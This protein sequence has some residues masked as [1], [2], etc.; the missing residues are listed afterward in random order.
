LLLRHSLLLLLLLSGLGLMIE[1]RRVKQPK[2]ACNTSAR[3]RASMVGSATT[4]RAAN[5]NTGWA[6]YCAC[7][8]MDCERKIRSIRI[9]ISASSTEGFGLA[10]RRY[11]SASRMLP[12]ATNWLAYS[13]YFCDKAFVDWP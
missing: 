9:A 11:S 1:W 6:W 12:V 8:A 10:T 4:G 5:G 13:L 7:T 3:S 2:T